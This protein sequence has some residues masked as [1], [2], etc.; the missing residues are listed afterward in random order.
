[1]S[2]MPL[3]PFGERERKVRTRR[4][5]VLGA[6]IDFRSASRA[7]LRLAEQAFASSSR[8]R[9]F[10]GEP[11][12]RIDLRLVEGIATRRMP[13]MRLSAGAGFLCG[14]LDRDNFAVIAPAARRALVVVS[15]AMLKS[16]HLVRYELIEF[17][18]L[19]LAARA[20]QLV[21]L[22]AA[23]VGASDRGLLLLGDSGAGKSTLSLLAVLDGLQLVGEDSVFLSHENLV[24]HGAATFLHVQNSALRLVAQARDRRDIRRAPVIRR[25]SGA[26]KYAFDLRTRPR[27][28]APRPQR[29]VG[30]VLL[31]ATRAR[32]GAIL[33]RISKPA[34]L[35]ALRRTQPYAVGLP[36]WRLVGERLGRLPAWRLARGAKA[37][38]SVVELRRLLARKA[39]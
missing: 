26:R 4:M 33:T 32:R 15:R 19:T 37:A 16:A 1:M 25:R 23:C 3:D 38:D 34:L 31:S 27:A 10:A 5:R 35:A 2:D 18:A 39:A 8:P 21:P 36:E 6:S 14:S 28:L 9:S 17:A 24:A 12:L 30:L 22:H 13:R 11:R 7:L 20:R 29:V